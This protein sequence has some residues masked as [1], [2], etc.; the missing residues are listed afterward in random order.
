MILRLA[1]LDDL[2]L[3]RDWDEKP[4]VIRASGDDDCYDW[5]VE[6]PRTVPWREFLIAVVDGRAIG[7]I[8]IIDP[9]EEET[10]YWGSCE[11]NLRAIDTWIGEQR[12]LGQGHGTRMMGLAIDRCFSDPAVQ[13]IL[14]DP[15]VSNTGAIRFYERL[16]FR[17]IGRQTFG[18]DD[19]YVYRLDRCP[20]SRQVR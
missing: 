7:C 5:A 3:L 14:L 16:G 9:A 2:P 4:H 17:R 18:R 13:A 10:H 20:A 6:L 1:T 15:L 12:D 8:Q 11:P 19:C